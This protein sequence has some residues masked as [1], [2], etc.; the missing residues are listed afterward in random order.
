MK[1][2]A[3]DLMTETIY[4]NRHTNSDTDGFAFTVQESPVVRLEIF[5][6]D[7]EYFA[8]ERVEETRER[9]RRHREFVREDRTTRG[10]GF[11]YWGNGEPVQ[12]IQQAAYLGML[13]LENVLSAEQP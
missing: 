1:E 2:Q 4:T 9:L 11:L 3:K 8:R 5:G 13:E 12:R 10:I 6:M 7:F